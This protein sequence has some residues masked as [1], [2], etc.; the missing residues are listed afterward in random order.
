MLKGWLLWHRLVILS[1]T[2]SLYEM[3]LLNLCSWCNFVGF[4]WCFNF[5]GEEDPFPTI[6]PRYDDSYLESEG[7]EI[8]LN[9]SPWLATYVCGQS[10]AKYVKV[11]REMSPTEHAGFHKLQT[12][13]SVFFID[14][15]IR[16]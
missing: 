16:E 11:G 1:H 5:F 2:V 12:H 6:K 13:C 9:V 8:N 4:F 15:F 7:A 3:L 10:P 14:Y